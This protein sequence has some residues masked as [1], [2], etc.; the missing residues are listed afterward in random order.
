MHICIVQRFDLN[1][2]SIIIKIE[3]IIIIFKELNRRLKN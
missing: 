1:F 3:I 2:R